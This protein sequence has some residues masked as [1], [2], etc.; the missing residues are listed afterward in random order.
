MLYFLTVVATSA[1]RRHQVLLILFVCLVPDNI[2]PEIK[3]RINTG[4]RQL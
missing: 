3:I 4:R 2:R 1:L